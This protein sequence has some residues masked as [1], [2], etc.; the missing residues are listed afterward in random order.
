MTTTEES[1][2]HE[3]RGSGGSV[4]KR[5]TGRGRS[6]PGTA[7]ECSGLVRTGS[8]APDLMVFCYYRTVANTKI[9]EGGTCSSALMTRDSGSFV[10][11][12]S[13]IESSPV[14]HIFIL[15]NVILL[16]P[17]VFY[18]GSVQSL[19]S[20]SLPPVCT[21]HLPPQAV[22]VHQSQIL[23]PLVVLILRDLSHLIGFH[24]FEYVRHFLS[25][26]SLGWI[27]SPSATT[28]ASSTTA[29]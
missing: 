28:S 4:T 10:T 24:T 18:H 26:C 20:L 16:L 25:T 13:Y 22:P 14:G 1:R 12:L 11:V 19:S 21:L 17:R 27:T 23:P 5:G 3:S 15:F 9:P 2:I 8:L 29:T 6:F 7:R